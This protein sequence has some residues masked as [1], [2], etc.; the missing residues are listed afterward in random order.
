M[1]SRK[2][3]LAKN[4]KTANFKVNTKGVNEPCSSTFYQSI[5][6]LHVHYTMMRIFKYIQFPEIMNVFKIECI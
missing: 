1:N 2:L 6:Y 4:A 5:L 3:I